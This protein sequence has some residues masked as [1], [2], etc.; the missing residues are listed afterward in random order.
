MEV[1]ASNYEQAAQQAESLK[2]QA[3]AILSNPDASEADLI[4]AQELMNKYNRIMIAI[5]EVLKKEGQAES[6]AAKNAGAA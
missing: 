1:T 2:N 3:D 5:S 4:R 6:T